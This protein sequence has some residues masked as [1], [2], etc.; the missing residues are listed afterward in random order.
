MLGYGKARGMQK[1]VPILSTLKILAG[2]AGLFIFGCAP[3]VII[4]PPTPTG[5]GLTA[6][7]S[8]PTP[9]DVWLALLEKSPA[10]LA[11]R[12]PEAGATPLDGIYAKIDQS[13]PQWW[14][15]RRCADYRP[16]GGIWKLQ[17]Y[18]GVMCIYYDV[19]GWSSL[20]SYTVSGDE[21][22]LFNDLYCYDEGVYRWRLA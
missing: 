3:S 7:T 11:T 19:T 9:T 10:A 8:I 16:A 12:L 4:T 17:F 18:R 21:R 2:I 5:A 22:H 20:A 14:L 1:K 13:W 6:T 15:C